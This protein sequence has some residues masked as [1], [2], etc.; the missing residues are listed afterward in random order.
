MDNV[1]HRALSITGPAMAFTIATYARSI[2][3]VNGVPPR[4]RRNR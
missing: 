4:D 1:D 2:E 3:G